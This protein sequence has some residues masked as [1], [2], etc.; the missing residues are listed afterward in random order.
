MVCCTRSFRATS[1]TPG[2]EAYRDTLLHSRETDPVCQQ[3][4]EAGQPWSVLL[5][6]SYATLL[7]ESGASL[8]TVRE[9]MGYCSVT[10]T[11]RYLFFTTPDAKRAAVKALDFLA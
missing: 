5:R 6:A 2:S 1:R 8:E 11:E 9:L 7:L 3:D 4:R 10:V